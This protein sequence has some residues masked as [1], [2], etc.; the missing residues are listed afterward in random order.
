[1]A[2]QPRRLDDPIDTREGEHTAVEPDQDGGR[3]PWSALLAGAAFMSTGIA[4]V[5]HV[6]TG[7][8]LPLVVAAVLVG[9]AIVGALI[10]RDE[11]LAWWTRHKRMLAVGAAA[12]VVSTAVY[13][14]SRWLLVLAGGLPSSPYAAFPF[15]G[16]AIVGPGAPESLVQW[17]GTGFHFLNG[18]AF[19]MAYAVWL[20]RR[21]WWWG[22][23][24]G[25][26]LE[27]FMLAIYPGWLDIRAIGE[28][29]SI[30]VLGHVCYGATLGGLVVWLRR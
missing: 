27:A 11:P 24:F 18:I 9:V 25:L 29:T 21:S 12:G 19:A 1:M 22:I 26:G 6:L 16:R 17:V 4:L 23:L 14:L 28:F 5:A 3:L 20:G 13:D 30:S 2:D 10:Y 15:F 8:P 7:A